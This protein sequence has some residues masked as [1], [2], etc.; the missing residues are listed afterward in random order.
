MSGLF[1][2]HPLSIFVFAFVVQCAAAWIGDFLRRRSTPIDEVARKDFGTILPA[3]LTLLGLI[4]G[5][6]FSMASSRYDQRKAL[7]EA[8][9]NAI[10]TEYVRA[11]LMPAAQAAPLWQVDR[12]RLSPKTRRAKQVNTWRLWWDGNANRC[13]SPIFRLV[14]SRQ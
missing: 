2:Q 5:F 7:E 3:S 10:G 4:I 9:A 8:E 12:R 14:L 13:R 6:S 1:D 11:D